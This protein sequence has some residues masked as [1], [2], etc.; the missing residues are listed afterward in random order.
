M[1]TR[2]IVALLLA[3]VMVLG[4]FAACGQPDQPDT[5]DTPDTKD[6]TQEAID[7]LN[8]TQALVLQESTFDGVFSPFFY[9]NAYDGDICGLIFHSLLTM[10]ASGAIVA[11]EQYPTLAKSYEIYY[12]DANGNRHSE[13]AAGD[14]V[15]YEMVL[16]NGQ[17]FSDGSAV[18]A[19]D[20]LFSLY[21]FLDPQYDGSSTLYTMPVLGYTDYKLQ[22]KGAGALM[23]EAANIFAAGKDKATTEK[24]KYFWNEAFPKAGEAFAQDIVNYV[25][26]NYAA[27]AYV[28][29]YFKAGMT[30]ADVAKSDALKVAYG[31]ALWG[32]G[33]FN[34]AGKFETADGK[35]VD[36]LNGEALTAADYWTAIDVAY[37]GDYVNAESTESAGAPLMSAAYELYTAHYGQAGKV[38]S[39]SGI[40]KGETTIDGEKYETVKV[41]LTEQ[42]PKAILNMTIT[43]VPMAYYTSGYNY[44]ADAVVVAGVELNNPAFID[45][46][47][48]FNNAPMGAGTYKMSK[49]PE[50]SWYENNT[51]YLERNTYFETLGTEITNAKIKNVRCVV[52]TSGGEYDAIDAGD[53]MYATVSATADVM[54]D[55]GKVDDLKGILVDNNGYGYICINPA[56]YKNVNTR[57]ALTTLMNLE[58]VYDYYPNGL[59]DVIYR[60]QTQVSWSYP[61][62]ATAMY[63]YDATR[64]QAKAYFTKAGFTWENGVMIDPET[65]AQA[66]FK[67]TLP[68]DA[69]DHPAGKIFIAL[70]EHLEA[71]GAKAEIVVDTNVIANI[72]VAPVGMYALA[73]SSAADPDMYQV[74]HYNSS[75]TSVFSNGIT[76]VYGE[77]YG[78]EL[79]TIEVTKLNGTKEEM[80]QYEALLYLG[81]LIEDGLK[82]MTVE[83]RKP[84][85]VAALDL[86]AQ[87]NIEIPTYQRKNLFVYDST[88][89]DGSSLNQNVTPYWSPLAEIWKVSF[90]APAEAK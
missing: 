74:Y 70:G 11:G 47:K 20:V 73:W 51:I 83:E 60:S 40:V 63:P 52:V 28:D 61:E 62:N 15:V 6:P 87:L 84:I 25:N 31:M 24:E 71:L 8:E 85:Y 44:P 90:A 43:V 1:N 30:Y 67:M 22:M 57:I 80:N 46:L 75:A 39:I 68:S 58:L 49:G 89:I 77:A 59:A 9:S 86:L 48:K 72:K 29:A 79:G 41:I 33:G 5:P 13:Y 14:Y 3:L 21:T 81:E 2:K 65:K 36:V 18:S 26:A 19:D 50:G 27:D 35:V 34:E 69:A 78:D 16:K 38:E 23:T 64:E 7:N 42:N 37:A 32:F 54:E 88:Y 45:H 10:D 66:E 76:T 12:T 53:V 4:M 82:Y 55:L 56:V 17:K